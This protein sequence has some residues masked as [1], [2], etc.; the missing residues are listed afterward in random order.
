[1]CEPYFIAWVL[2]S[3][4]ELKCEVIFGTF[5]RWVI[6]LQKFVADQILGNV[7]LVDI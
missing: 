7:G 3:V 2:K 6:I 4:V 1:M 5:S